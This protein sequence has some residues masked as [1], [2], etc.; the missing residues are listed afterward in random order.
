MVWLPGDYNQGMEKLIDEIKYS[1]RKTMVIEVRL[2]GKVIV[3]AP[4]GTKPAKIQ[5]FVR[6]K[7]SWIQKAK[8]RM[9]GLPAVTRVYSFVQGEKLLFLGKEYPLTIMPKVKG[10]LSFSKEKGFL[11][12]SDRQAEAAKL[13]TKLYR[14]ETRRLTTM[15]A[16]QY[17]RKWGLSYRSI[18][19]TGAKTRWGSCSAK[20]SLNFTY[21]LA[22]LPL[23]MVDYVVAH[24]LAHTR[25][26]N[27]SADFWGFLGQMLPEFQTRRSWLKHNARNLPDF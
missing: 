13:L 24:E 21:R 1:R 4:L 6:Q 10:G 7:A 25:H 11:L 9:Q 20:N 27:H 2:G 15:I 5:A 12:Q 23:D 18:R 3:R 17:A 22:M 26:H 19:I 8:T 16:D 14:E